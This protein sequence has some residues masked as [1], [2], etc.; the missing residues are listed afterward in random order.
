MEVRGEWNEFEGVVEGQHFEEIKLIGEYVEEEMRLWE[1]I[2]S[3][4]K[5]IQKAII[6]KT[7]RNHVNKV[8]DK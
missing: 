2:T 3:Y 8:E 7:F 6:C 5:A 1:E 4:W